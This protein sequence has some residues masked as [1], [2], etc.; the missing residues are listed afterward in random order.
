M[1]VSSWAFV[2]PFQLSLQ[3][4]RFL[5]STRNLL[6]QR[7]NMVSL[8]VNFFK[9]IR[10]LSKILFKLC[11]KHSDWFFVVLAFHFLKIHSSWKFCITWDFACSL[12]S[13]CKRY[14]FGFSCLF[15]YVMFFPLFPL[16]PP[17]FPLEK[18]YRHTFV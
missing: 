15:C 11:N 3:L 2:M 14:I 9:L 18:K 8:L 6:F 17:S 13:H 12:E 16:S 7:M 1:P 10:E 4:E 5:S